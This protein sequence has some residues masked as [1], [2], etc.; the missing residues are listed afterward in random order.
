MSSIFLGFFSETVF[1]YFE[2]INRHDKPG[3]GPDFM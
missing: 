2:V 3:H 1:K